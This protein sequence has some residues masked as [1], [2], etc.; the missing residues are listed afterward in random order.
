MGRI[1]IKKNKKNTKK[2]PKRSSKVIKKITKTKTKIKIFK[3]LTKKVL[4]KKTSVKKPKKSD[5]TL[6]EKK[7]AGKLKKDEEKKVLKMEK[8]IQTGKERGFITYGEIL[9]EFP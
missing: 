2:T 8:L 4:T 6:Q 9:R 5:L 1:K 7:L 3:K